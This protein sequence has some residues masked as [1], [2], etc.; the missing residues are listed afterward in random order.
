MLRPFAALI[1]AL[2]ILLSACANS[3]PPC[4]IANSV[5]RAPSAGCLVVVHNRIL[6]VE[7]RSG[8]ISPPGG[9]ASSGESAQCA[10]HRESYEETGL[11]LMPGDLVA[12]FESGFNL[13]Y[14]AIHA[15]SGGLEPVRPLEIGR[16]FWL[17][18]DD[19]AATDWRFEGQG[20]VLMDLLQAP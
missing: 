5:D 7:G 14:C 6:V 16:A 19:F 3:A 10:A 1:P 15:D 2:L 9:K 17:H 12:T 8:R 11:D 4:P 13:Y 20:Q 18:G